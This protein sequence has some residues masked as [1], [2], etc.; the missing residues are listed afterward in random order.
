MNNQAD[1]LYLKWSNWIDILDTEIINLHTQRHIFQEVQ[2][3]LRA[4]PKVQSPDDF[5][6]WMAVW[7]ASAMSVSVRKQAD[8]DKNSIS[9]RRL[10]EEIKANPTVISR[11]RFKKNFVDG[12]NYTEAD[13][14]EGFNQIIGVGRQYI[15]PT[16]VDGEINELEAKTDK[17]R[18]YV[19]KRIA[20][21]DK[22]DF[23]AIPKFSDLTEAIDYLGTLHKRY[24]LIFRCFSTDLLIVWQY[25]WKRVFRYPWIDSSSTNETHE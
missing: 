14:N 12:W 20:H 2:E 1:E 17:L 24:Y 9:Y 4:N 23:T 5:N 15:D 21:H 13:A 18:H 6:F 19:N 7:Y 25:D 8:N 3:I 10:L 11:E 22:K 16:V